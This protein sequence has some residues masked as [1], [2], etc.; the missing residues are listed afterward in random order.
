MNLRSRAVCKGERESMDKGS[1]K[2]RGR[3][4]VYCFQNRV[5][6]RFD[7]S[8]E[9]LIFAPNRTQNG[10]IERLDV[11]QLTPE[12]IVDMLV[13]TEVSIVISGGIQKRFK[14]V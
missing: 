11:S 7:T 1:E 13:D 6:P 2:T 3:I 4:A 5:C 12:R 10:P 14:T 9:I 8:P